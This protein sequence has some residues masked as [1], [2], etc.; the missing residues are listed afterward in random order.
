MLESQPNVYTPAL[1]N[2]GWQIGLWNLIGAIGFTV[3]P[4][5]F[6]L[7]IYIFLGEGPQKGV[8]FS[9]GTRHLPLQISPASNHHLLSFI[10]HGTSRLLTHWLGKLDAPPP[11]FKSSAASSCSRATTQAS[12]FRPASRRSGAHGH[13]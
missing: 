5:L 9:T 12:S 3:C 4:N 2:L 10:P 1:H 7:S 8:C 6:L 13:F 11:K